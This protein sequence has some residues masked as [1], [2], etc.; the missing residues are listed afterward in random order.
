M[1]FQSVVNDNMQKGFVG[2][3]RHRIRDCTGINT[4]ASAQIP[5]G[6]VVVQNKAGGFVSVPQAAKL[7]TA[8]GDTVL[9]IREF[10]HRA[11]EDVGT[12]GILPQRTF[13]ILQSGEI[14][15]VAETTITKGQRAFFR[16]TA[17]GGLTQLGAL[18]GDADS[19]NAVELKGAYFKDGGTAGTK[20]WLRLDDVANRATQAS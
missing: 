5:V 13:P 12:T 9:G 17:N 8:S 2:H 3:V 7:P 11:P 18:R 1:A 19:G 20:L 4:E 6:V 15:V 16:I 10:E 14:L